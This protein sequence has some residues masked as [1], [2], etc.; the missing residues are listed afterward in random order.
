MITRHPSTLHVGVAWREVSETFLILLR[1]VI[2]FMDVAG[3]VVLPVHVAGNSI[4]PRICTGVANVRSISRSGVQN[5]PKLLIWR[6]DCAGSAVPEELL[7]TSVSNQL[8]MF[9]PMANAGAALRV[10]SVNSAVRLKP[11]K[12]IE[13]AASLAIPIAC[14]AEYSINPLIYFGAISANAIL[15]CA[16]VKKMSCAKHVRHKLTRTSVQ[17]C[18]VRQQM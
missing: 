2:R 14:V 17:S 18:H 6:Q 11:R 16:I 10:I 1:V 3:L 7:V 4:E 15:Q 5:V 9:A 12:A 13:D 8:N